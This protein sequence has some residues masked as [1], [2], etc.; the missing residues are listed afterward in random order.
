MLIDRQ[1]GDGTIFKRRAEKE[2]D[3]MDRG[4]SSFPDNNNGGKPRLGPAHQATAGGCHGG[5]GTREQHSTAEIAVQIVAV[6]RTCARTCRDSSF[7]F[8]KKNVLRQAGGSSPE[9]G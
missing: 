4:A 1:L 8:S 3:Q 7:R 9:F 5:A 6:M 2:Q